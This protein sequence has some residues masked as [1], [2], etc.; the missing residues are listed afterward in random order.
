[1]RNNLQITITFLLIFI[2]AFSNIL[3]GQWT[4]NIGTQQNYNSNPF[5]SPQPISTM[6]TSID[7]GIG[8]NWEEFG[9]GYFG[10]FSLFHQIDSRNYYWHQAGIWN[11]TDSSI[12][13][14]YFEQRRN[15]EEFN[16]YNYSNYNIYAKNKFLFKGINIFTNVLLSATDYA[17]LN[18]LDNIWGGLGLLLNKSFETKT[19][20][21]GGANY[22]YKNYFSTDLNDYELTGDTLSSSSSKAFV[23]QISYF[24]RVAQSLTEN[25]GIAL[26]YS[27]KE[28]LGGTASYVRQLEYI[29]GDE[30]QYFDD[31]ISYNSNFYSIQLTQILPEDIIFRL[32]FSNGEKDYPSQGIYTDPV[33]FD[34]NSI[35]VDNQSFLQILLSKDIY[36]GMDEQN[37]ISIQ[38][39][40]DIVSNESNS[41]WYNYESRSLNFGIDFEF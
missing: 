24:G 6:I 4:F 3:F 2:S 1:M 36:T 20:L 12:Y 22:N 26:Q 21:I 25:T 28:I 19:T 8:N 38:L 13:G 37:T 7:F 33:N 15:A 16:Y 9:I 27:I 35:R 14:F 41:Y 18:D 17:E 40:Y 34:Q 23:S 39:S 10:S 30:S 29:Y 11:S 5:N 31:P 32:K